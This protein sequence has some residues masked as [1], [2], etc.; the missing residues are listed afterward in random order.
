MIGEEYQYWSNNMQYRNKHQTI[1][2]SDD[3]CFWRDQTH[4]FHRLKN[5]S[6]IWRFLTSVSSDTTFHFSS[7]FQFQQKWLIIFWLL[8]WFNLKIHFYV[9]I[10]SLAICS[11][12]VV[13][14]FHIFEI[15]HDK[16]DE[17]KEKMNIFNW[18]WL[19]H[20]AKNETFSKRRC[21]KKRNTD[22]KI[23]F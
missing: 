3:K 8:S 20:N 15:D 17:R 6:V 11:I 10:F 23:E 22:F 13:L 5:P 18:L 4:V 19:N 21:W 12:F 9:W 16:F 14:S 7:H 1:H 2:H